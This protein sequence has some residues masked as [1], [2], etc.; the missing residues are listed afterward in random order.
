MSLETLD[1]NLG[2][3]G[4][5]F[6]SLGKVLKELQGYRVDVVAGAAAGVLMPLA[7][8]RT[9]DTI[10]SVVV[11]TDAGGALTTDT[12]NV[13]I[14]STKAFGTITVT[15]DPLTNETFVVNGV[16]YT[17][18]AIPTAR[19]HVKITA[20]NNTAMAAAIR[21]AI[22]GYENRYTG[23]AAVPIIVAT[24][25]L[26]VCTVTAPVGG[27]AGN[28]ITFTE[29]VTGVAMSGSGTITGGTATSNIVSTTN[30]TGKSL[31]VHWYS[32]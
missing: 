24:S 4:A 26:G 11:H 31:I 30:L 17:F 2:Q 20:G 13:S 8:I 10:L 7:A 9:K 22:N 18:K 25:A 23:K 28:A 16:T 21:D 29:S 1:S 6:P 12:P 27:V 32:K 5:G 14:V 15:A 3:G 19:T